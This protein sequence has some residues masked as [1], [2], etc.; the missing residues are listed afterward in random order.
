MWLSRTKGFPHLQE[1]GK[2]ITLSFRGQYEGWVSPLLSAFTCQTEKVAKLGSLGE[3]NQSCRQSHP[4]INS[5]F[6]KILKVLT[7]WGDM[8]G[9][10]T[11]GKK[12][13]EASETK[14][15]SSGGIHILLIGVGECLQLYMW[16]Q[17]ESSKCVLSGCLG[18]FCQLLWKIHSE[19]GAGKVGKSRI[20]LQSKRYLEWTLNDGEWWN[21]QGS[22]F[23]ES[24]LILPGLWGGIQYSFRLQGPPQNTHFALYIFKKLCQDWRERTAVRTPLLCTWLTKVGPSESIWS[25]KFCQEWSLSEKSGVNPEHCQVW[26][27]DHSSSHPK[28]LSSLGSSIC[29]LRC[30]TQVLLQA[31]PRESFCRKL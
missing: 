24:P 6:R 28:E 31:S 27:I 9:V 14:V 25:T 21:E 22:Q 11:R 3:R 18:S 12:M 2:T 5:S 8:L 15:V 23:L 4:L 26:P 30:W 10:R 16:E 19:E 20:E 1:K 29:L 13:E 17:V 7:L